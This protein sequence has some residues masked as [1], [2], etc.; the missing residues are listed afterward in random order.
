MDQ[1]FIIRKKDLANDQKELPHPLDSL[2]VRHTRSLG[3][4][5]GLT[6][7]GVH[8]VT[9]KPG[10]RSTVEHVHKISDEFAY[11]ISGAGTV[12]LDGNTFSLS[13][14]D[15]IGFPANGPAHTIINNGDQDL[16]YIMGGDRPPFDVVRYPNMKKQLYVYDEKGQ[17][18]KDVADDVHISQM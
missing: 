8:F 14:G 5:V 15:F 4:K 6:K 7:V 12:T 1:Q 17:R 10:N 3:D 16:V 2:A 9:L 13:E 11:I 18:K